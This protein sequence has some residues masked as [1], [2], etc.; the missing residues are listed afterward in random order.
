MATKAS[1][2]QGFERAA[3]RAALHSVPLD[4][5]YDR[6]R[7]MRT[8]RKLALTPAKLADT[9]TDSPSDCP[10]AGIAFRHARSSASHF[11]R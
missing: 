9:I 10:V 2:R 6:R 4:F 5:P 11:R 3:A 1:H 8:L 7:D